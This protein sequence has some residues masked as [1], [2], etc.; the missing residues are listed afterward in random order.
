MAIP[1]P[2]ALNGVLEMVG[3]A[4]DEV[5]G[6]FAVQGLIGHH[7]DIGR[8]EKHLVGDALE[9]IDGLLVHVAENALDDGLVLELVRHL[10]K[11]HALAKDNDLFTRIGGRERDVVVDLFEDK[12]EKT[13]RTISAHERR[14]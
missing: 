12:H 6:E 8:N 10:V 9:P 5:A 13:P 4:D 2:R 11:A 1:P 14:P 3:Q 7:H